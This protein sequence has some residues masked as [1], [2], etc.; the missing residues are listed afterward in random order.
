MLTI[1]R[2]KLTIRKANG[3]KLNTIY[4]AKGIEEDLRL[5]EISTLKFDIPYY[6]LDGNGNAILNDDGSPI[7]NNKIDLLIPENIVELEDRVYIIKIPTEIKDSDGVKSIR[8]E[9]HEMASDL[10][11]KQIKY[12]NLYPPYSNPVDPKR[13][14]LEI[15]TYPYQQDL[16]Y[17]GFSAVS[18]TSLTLNVNTSFDFTGYYIAILDG[19]GKYQQRKIVSYNTGTK[20][21]VVDSVFSPQVDTSTSVFRIHNSRFLLG[22][23]DADIMIVDGSPVFRSLKFEDTTIQEALQTTRARFEGNLVYSTVRDDVENKYFVTIGLKRDNGASGYEFRYRKNLNGIERTVDSSNGCYTRVYPEGR[24]NLSVVSVATDTRTD[25]SITYNAHELGKGDIY[26]F[27][28]Y[29]GIGYTLA[30]C[31]D[32]FVKDFRFIEDAYVDADDLYL[33]ASQ[34]LEELSVPKIEY[35]ISGFDFSKTNLEIFTGVN[36]IDLNVGDVVRVIDDEFGF[37]FNATIVGLTRNYDEPYKPRIDLSNFT[38]TLGDI[39]A[40]IIKYQEGYSERKSL[41]GKSATIVIA[42]RATSRNWRYADYVVPDDG[43]KTA[44]EILQYAID[45][46]SAEYGG[47]D[48]YLAEGSY[49]FA[50][51]P[52]L[53]DGVNVYGYGTATRIYP[54]GSPSLAFNINNADN[55]SVKDLFIDYSRDTDGITELSSFQNGIG[56]YN[57]SDSVEVGNC[58]FDKVGNNYIIGIESSNLN[59]YNN[60]I[61]NQPG[62]GFNTEAIDLK[63]C[64]NASVLRNKIIGEFVFQNVILVTNQVGTSSGEFY[65]EDNYIKLTDSSATLTMIGIGVGDDAYVSCSNNTLITEGSSATVVGTAIGVGSTRYDVFN[66]SIN[67]TIDY[68]GHGMLFYRG[69]S[70]AENSSVRGNIFNLTCKTGGVPT[71]RVAIYFETTSYGC[72][73]QNNKVSGHN[74]YDPSTPTALNYGC[75]VASG[76]TNNVISGNDFSNNTTVSY[77]NF[78]T[79]TLTLGGNK[80]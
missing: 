58:L 17:G 46:I 52:N 66:N 79:G 32:L 4:N 59:I 64:N 16:G 60:T 57:G 75:F 14:I 42:D 27:Q 24:N 49:G 72:V 45:E 15:I 9:C 40:K 56:I 65:I 22:D 38:D 78:G 43:T 23:I 63:A 71:D 13:A 2:P 12:L 18:G 10:G 77:Q 37:D 6:L 54:I 70:L 1:S 26:N 34:A 28:Y 30:E 29:L 33:G 25:S 8:V 7:K 35:R 44:D 53:K 47:G 68:S 36:Q 19:T 80:L 20:V 3:V 62:G 21:A 31:Y 11:F 55:C 41:Y 61:K 67:V 50:V 69:G 51:T 73:F 48:I 76:A 39:Y 5:G 74:P